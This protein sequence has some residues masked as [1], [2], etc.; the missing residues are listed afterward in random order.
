MPRDNK[1]SC[2]CEVTLA[3]GQSLLRGSS[4]SRVHVNRPLV[5]KVYAY[6]LGKLALQATIIFLT[7]YPQE[8]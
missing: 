6:G 5:I 2:E 8:Q 1:P 3:P 7:C 4:L